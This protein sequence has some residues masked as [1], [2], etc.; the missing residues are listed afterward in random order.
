[1]AGATADVVEGVRSAYDQI[2]EAYSAVNG[3]Q[4]PE[5]LLRLEHNLL[6]HVGHG[7]RLIDVGCGVGRD[8]GW[9]ESQGVRVNGV[10][11][12]AGVLAHARRL[13][14]SPL[15]LMDM[16]RL[17]FRDA[18]F[19]GGWCCASLLHLPKREAPGALGAIRR[20]LK[21]GAMLVLSVQEG[22]CEAWEG[23]YVQGVKR[24]FA[25]YDRAGM[26]AILAEAGFSVRAFDEEHSHRDWLS[27]V[28]IAR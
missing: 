12:S 11:L 27:F 3:G 19:D 8:M 17:A 14:A 18:C 10:D 16:R 13:T 28:C 21:G 24:F 6:G 4:M 7:A 26:E 1:M 22:D 5:A 23:G 9:F 15:L 2:A 25:R 20:V